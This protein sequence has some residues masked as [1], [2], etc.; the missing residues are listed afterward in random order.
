MLKRYLEKLI[1]FGCS[2]QDVPQVDV[3]YEMPEGYIV[4]Y[5]PG[6]QGCLYVDI[7]AF[8]KEGRK[9]LFALFTELRRYYQDY[10]N[11]EQSHDLEYVIDANAFA[12]MVMKVYFGVDS[13]VS[14]DLPMTRVMLASHRLSQQLNIK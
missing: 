10:T 7:D 11:M 14:H 5:I 8:K 13:P 2:L 3:V 12:I 6:K 4:K 9:S 1:S